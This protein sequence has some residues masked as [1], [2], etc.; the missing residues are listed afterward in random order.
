MTTAHRATLLFMPNHRSKSLTVPQNERVLAALRELLAKHNNN[1]SEVARK[2]GVTQATISAF[3]SGKSGAGN[4]LVEA[5]MRAL[6]VSRSQLVDGAE[7]TMPAF[8]NAA[9]W[10]EAEQLVRRDMPGIPAWAW[11]GARS[12][13]GISVPC[14]I[15]K[16]F[17]MNAVLFILNSMP[18]EQKYELAKRIA[19]ATE[20]LRTTTPAKVINE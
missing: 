14:P 10:A 12:L 2:L 18:D 20:S 8:G 9:G 13:R 16:S 5:L 19:N 6:R 11:E 7:G 4:Q 17:V 3:L 15:T 1:Q